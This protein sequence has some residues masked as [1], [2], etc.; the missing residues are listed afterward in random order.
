MRTLWCDNVTFVIDIVGFYKHAD[1]Y[2]KGHIYNSLKIAPLTLSLNPLTTNFLPKNAVFNRQ[3]NFLA[4][5]TL[6]GP[7]F[8]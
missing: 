7:M 6:N 4:A 1:N 8:C 2:N 3:I 5:M